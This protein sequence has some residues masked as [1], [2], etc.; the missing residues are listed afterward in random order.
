[1]SNSKYNFVTWLVAIVL[2][3]Y[4]F[5]QWQHNHGMGGTCCGTPIAATP[6]PEPLAPAPIAEAFKCTATADKF[7]SSG[8]ASAVIWLNKSSELSSWLKAGGADW[9][10]SCNDATV[11]LSGSVDSESAKTKAGA[12][13]LAFFGDKV[14][15]DNQLTVKAVEK[16]SVPIATT[17]PTT[18]SL[19]FDT[20]K[21]Q[22]SNEAESSLA[23]IEE[24]L[25][26]NPNAKAIISGYHDPRGNKAIN[27]ELAKNRAKVVSA[28]L[29]LAGV[30]DARIELRKPTDTEGSG[31]LSQ[32][33]RVEVSVE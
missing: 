22:L 28:A 32:A 10:A 33:R 27:A 18:V 11:T 14:T 1:V 23:P 31:D 19:Y 13:A 12:D 17:A 2:A 30:D 24:W 8:D 9:Q 26:T 29:K 7:E 3:I 16:A 6:M 4:L 5:W 21:T 20:G 15:V 25:K